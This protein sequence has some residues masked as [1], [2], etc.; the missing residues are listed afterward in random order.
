[1]III[2]TLLMFAIIVY[3]YLKWRKQK[4]YSARINSYLI[5]A[6]FADL[7]QN[8]Q[9][10]VGVKNDRNLLEMV[11]N[12]LTQ[13]APV[14]HKVIYVISYAKFT[15]YFNLSIWLIIFITILYSVIDF[16][17]IILLFLIILA[18]CLPLMISLF[19]YWLNKQ[20]LIE[21]LP[22]SIDIMVSVLKSGHSLTEAIQAA[23]YESPQP[24]KTE[25]SQILHKIN[26]GLTFSQALESTCSNYDCHELTVIKSAIQIHNELGGSLAE[27]LNKTNYSLKLRIELAQKV[28][29][30]T[31][32]SKLTAIVVGA[33][34]FVLSFILQIISP[35][36]LNPLIKTSFGNLLLI[37]ALGLQFTGIFTMIKMAQ[38]KI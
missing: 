4:Q 26:F 36:Y 35:G 34:P 13:C 8:P 6:K 29:I 32:Q 37:I 31:S 24:L 20:K 7:T 14:Y 19:K 9:A 38:V 15:R 33:M 23:Q 27:L 11:I 28:K 12:L 18:V 1:M 5:K 16:N 25:L 22:D 21:S 30:L 17:F 10:V 3:L 2:L